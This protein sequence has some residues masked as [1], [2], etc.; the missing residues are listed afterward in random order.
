MRLEDDSKV[1]EG[2]FDDLRDDEN[3]DDKL[4][5]I[6]LPPPHGLFPE[7]SVKHIV[8]GYNYLSK[9]AHADENRRNR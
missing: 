8:I 6:S 3:T 2:K 4:S 9:E 1:E 5:Q 7:R